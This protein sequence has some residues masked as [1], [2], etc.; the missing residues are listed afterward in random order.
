MG[1][2]LFFYL[3]LWRGWRNRIDFPEKFFEPRSLV[4]AQHTLYL[5]IRLVSDLFIVRPKLQ[6]QVEI[7]LA[8][9]FK[10]IL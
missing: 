7:A 9:F 4:I 3:L 1:E 5:V 8:A 10:Y 2:L 6:S